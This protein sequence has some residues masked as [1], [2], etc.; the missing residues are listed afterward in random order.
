MN[1]LQQPE[2]EQAV[3]KDFFNHAARSSQ[4]HSDDGKLNFRQ[5]E[6]Y[7]PNQFSGKS[8]GYAELVFKREAYM[9]TLD[10]SAKEGEVLRAVVSS[11]MRSGTS[12]VF[13]TRREPVSCRGWT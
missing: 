3:T 13:T 1:K 9:S 2:T 10:P 7:V 4:S 11:E 12:Q 6:R 8:G 5:A